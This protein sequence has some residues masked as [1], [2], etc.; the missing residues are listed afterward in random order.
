MHMETG[1]GNLQDLNRATREIWDSKAQFWD[2]RMGEGNQFQRVLIGPAS[3]RLLQ[4]QPDQVILEIAC[5]NGVFS[6][7]LASLGAWVVATDFSATFLDLARARTTEHPERI[8]YRLVDATD[9]SQLLALGERRFDAAV[10]NMALM[11]M[12]TIAPLMRAHYHFH[13]SLSV[14]FGACFTAGFVLDGL[15]EPAF[16]PDDRGGRPLNWAN[17]TDVPPVLVARVRPA[18]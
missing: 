6:R 2:E 9:E 11:D 4:V 17:Y 16:G 8:E 5:G 13:R 12:V 1:Q 10:C 3:E 15:E 14:L 7:R 18:G